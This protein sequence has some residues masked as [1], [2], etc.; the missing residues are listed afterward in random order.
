MRILVAKRCVAAALALLAGSA[1]KGCGS[2]TSGSGTAG[3]VDQRSDGGRIPGC[4]SDG[5]IDMF[6]AEGDEVL[7]LSWN[8][9]GGWDSGGGYR[10][11]FGFTDDDRSNEMVIECSDLECEYNLTGLQNGVTYFL[12][13]ESLNADGEVTHV[14]CTISATPNPLMF[15][16]D[17]RV[18][19]A[20]GGVQDNPDIVAAEEGSPLFLAWEDGGAIRLVRSNDLGD[21]WG[22]PVAVGSGSGQASPSLAFRDR[23]MTDDFVEVTPVL[24]VAYSQG[25]EILLLR[26]VFPQGLEGAAAL[27]SP[28]LLGSGTNP[29][30][31]IGKDLVHVAFEDGERIFA[32]LVDPET[33]S[34]TAPVPVDTESGDSHAPSIAA[35]SVTGNVFV[36]Y[37]GHRGSGDTDV[38]VNVSTNGGESFGAE[39]IR[40]DD[41]SMGQNQLNISLAVD[42]R[43]GQILA[44]WEDRRGGANIFFSSSEDNGLTWGSNIETGAGLAGDQFTPQAVVDPGRNSYVVFIDTSD[45]QRPMFSRFNPDK[46][47]DPP[48]PVST[49]A[50]KAGAT[51]RNPAVAI[52]RFGTIYTTWSENRDSPDM[53]V[54]FARAE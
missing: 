47:F 54:Y 3:P 38:Y 52:D 23:V 53:D 18:H 13:V 45:G 40:I 24:Y 37:H 35:D 41:D 19:E 11:L 31:T 46:T 8:N 44:T 32:V 9:L 15:L 27:E 1:L 50:G 6:A 25:S 10:L 22:T 16:S 33:L 43:T 12:A 5:G 7:G 51:G 39:E 48:L 42:Q 4:L 49:A 17:V 28:V 36:A 29:D 30:V 20:T 2:T 34:A 14:S 21:T 26:T